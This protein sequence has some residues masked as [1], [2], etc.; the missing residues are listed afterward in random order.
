M[1]HFK[2]KTSSRGMFTTGEE[3][4]PESVECV[5]SFHYLVQDMSWIVWDKLMAYLGA[6]QQSNEGWDTDTIIY[7]HVRKHRQVHVGLD[8]PLYVPT[9]LFTKQ[10]KCVRFDP[11]FLLGSLMYTFLCLQNSE[12]LWGLTSSIL[13]GCGRGRILGENIRLKKINLV[14]EVNKWIKISFK[15]FLVLLI[16]IHSALDFCKY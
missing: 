14:E 2:S 11:P 13:V 10:Q 1:S 5:T 16:N 3:K 4:I 7:L 12:N 9:L 15:L 8:V 6:V